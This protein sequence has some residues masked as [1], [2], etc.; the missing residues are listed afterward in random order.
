MTAS[1]YISGNSD[2]ENN[3]KWI[4]INFQLRVK[5]YEWLIKC[6]SARNKNK[7]ADEKKNNQT[8]NLFTWK[9]EL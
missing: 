2:T 3:S 5:S 6:I 7:E 1:G 9:L 4:I 8:K